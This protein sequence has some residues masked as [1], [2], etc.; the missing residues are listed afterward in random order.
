[1]Y[2]GCYGLLRNIDQKINSRSVGCK[3]YPAAVERLYAARTIWSGKSSSMTASY[4]SRQQFTSFL[5]AQQP[6]SISRASVAQQTV[7]RSTV[8]PAAARQVKK[9]LRIEYIIK[10]LPLY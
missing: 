4:L 1:M 8:P 5:K 9:P 10:D 7:V 2:K 6:L 3:Q